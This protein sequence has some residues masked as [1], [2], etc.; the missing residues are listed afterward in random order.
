MVIE[1]YGEKVNHPKE[2][3]QRVAE[4]ITGYFERA[5]ENKKNFMPLDDGPQGQQPKSGILNKTGFD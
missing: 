2:L 4:K 1:T 5:L 3:L